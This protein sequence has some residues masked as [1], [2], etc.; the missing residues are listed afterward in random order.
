MSGILRSTIA[1]E[2]PRQICQHADDMT[3]TRNFG[4][5]VR[6][7]KA[8]ILLSSSNFKLKKLSDAIGR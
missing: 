8:A 2:D 6:F 7:L 4:S 5:G 1:A 3:G